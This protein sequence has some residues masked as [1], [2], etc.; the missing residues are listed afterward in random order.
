MTTTE[1][2]VWMRP[3]WISRV[4]LGVDLASGS[5]SGSRV[6][7]WVIPS[8]CCDVDMDVNTLGGTNELRGGCDPPRSDPVCLGTPYLCGCGERAWEGMWQ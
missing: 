3:E 4:H 6:V 1:H 2:D 5:R 8:E 7:P